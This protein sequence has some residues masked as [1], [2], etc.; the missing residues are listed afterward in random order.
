VTLHLREGSR[1]LCI[2][3]RPGGYVPPRKSDP[4]FD[5]RDVTAVTQATEV[6]CAA[7][8]ERQRRQADA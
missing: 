4:R 7:E 8:L 1:I 5:A 6:D 3:I 2:A